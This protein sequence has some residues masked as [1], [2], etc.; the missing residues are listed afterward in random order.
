MVKK[1]LDLKMKVV[2]EELKEY[3]KNYCNKNIYSE[4]VFNEIEKIV[5]SIN[6]REQ[7]YL[8]NKIYYYLGTD[9]C[10]KRVIDILRSNGYIVTQPEEKEIPEG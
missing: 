8:E 2:R 3:L 6:K 1:E 10:L 5:R 7:E 4:V 9:S